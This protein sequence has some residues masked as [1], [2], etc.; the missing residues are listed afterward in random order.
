VR[1]TSLLHFRK[2]LK[3]FDKRWN[4]WRKQQG[5]GWKTP[6]SIYNDERYFRNSVR[7]KRP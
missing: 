4:D 1:F 5:L 6:T 3:K 7:K 2:E